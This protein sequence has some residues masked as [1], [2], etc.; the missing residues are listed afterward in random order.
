MHGELDYRVPYYQ[1]LAYYNTLRA[2]NILS[3]LVFFLMKIIG[4]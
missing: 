1:G 2:R 4:F 3:R